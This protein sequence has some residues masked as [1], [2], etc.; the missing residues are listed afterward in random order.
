M[1]FVL[2]GALIL[3]NLYWMQRNERE[4][5]CDYAVCVQ[6]R[7][8]ARIAA[9]NRHPVVAGH[10][11]N[12]HYL[13]ARLSGVSLTVPSWVAPEQIWYLRRVAGLD[14]T[15]SDHPLLVA[16]EEARRMSEQDGNPRRWLRKRGRRGKS[17]WSD[18]HL[19]RD[20]TST[21]Y[22]MAESADGER[23]LFLLPESQYQKVA[24]RGSS[25]TPPAN[26]GAP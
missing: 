12:Y 16:P 11:S 15:V 14:I 24:V 10:V 26:V 3:H 4:I 17:V 9:S 22:V 23:P 25:V 19:R 6:P 18:L 13:A 2:L 1:S 21:R 20:G 7:G 8:L 5:E